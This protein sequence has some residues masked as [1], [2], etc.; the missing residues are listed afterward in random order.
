MP[1]HRDDSEMSRFDRQGLRRFS[2]R[3]A[4]LAVCVTM[5]LLVLLSGSSVRKAGEER[6]PGI[7]RDI[8]TAVGEPTNWAADRLPLEDASSE[9]TSALSPNEDLD[10]GA[11]FDETLSRRQAGGIP[12]VTPDAFDPVELGAAAAARRPLQTLLVTGDSLAQPL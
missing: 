6:K 2:A 4:V 1:T 3:D 8:L 11:S 12:L 9:L 5:L 7:G 10:D